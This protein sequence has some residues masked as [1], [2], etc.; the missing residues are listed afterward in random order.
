M[1]NWYTSGR[2]DRECGPSLHTMDNYNCTSTVPGH[3]LHFKTHEKRIFGKEAMRAMNNFT[4]TTKSSKKCL[5]SSLK[6]GFISFCKTCS[7]SSDFHSVE[8]HLSSS[9]YLKPRFLKLQTVISIMLPITVSFKFVG[10][11]ACVQNNINFSGAKY[12]HL[13]E[14]SNTWLK[15]HY[16]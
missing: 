14:F 10:C 6:F 9:P 11:Y 1:R 5:V 15:F 8:H 16:P 2:S 12:L 13:S 7:L 4:V 3:L